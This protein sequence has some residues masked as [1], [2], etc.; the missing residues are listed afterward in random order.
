MKWKKSMKINFKKINCWIIKLK[1][2]GNP[3]KH[4]KLVMWLIRQTKKQRS[5]ILNKKIFSEEI[6]KKQRKKEFEI[7]QVNLLNLQLWAWD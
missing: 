1:N 4:S 7:T 6:K 2:K 3:C 5:K